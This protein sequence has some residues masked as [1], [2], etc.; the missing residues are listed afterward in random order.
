MQYYDPK[1]LIDVCECLKL[2]FSIYQQNDASE[3]CDKLLDCIESALKGGC[4]NALGDNFG[5]TLAS[6]KILKDPSKKM[7][8]KEREEA[9][10]KV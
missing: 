8:C 3:F 2:E 1:W 7:L 10:I 5:G 9:F 6:Q 4:S